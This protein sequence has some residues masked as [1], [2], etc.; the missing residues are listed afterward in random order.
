[1][2]QKIHPRGVIWVPNPCLMWA[3]QL[4]K[5]WQQFRPYIMKSM[6]NAID[7]IISEGAFSILSTCMFNKNSV[8]KK[9]MLLKKCQVYFSRHVS[10]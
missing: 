1:M 9:I 2:V 4:K 8:Q 3:D 10:I 6:A 7:E 5:N